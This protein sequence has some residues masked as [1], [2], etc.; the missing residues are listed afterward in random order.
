MH[1]CEFKKWLFNDL[2]KPKP[3]VLNIFLIIITIIILY[4][5]QCVLCVFFAV[6]LFFICQYLHVTVIR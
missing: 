3:K 6:G 2:M 5:F 1:G 4:V